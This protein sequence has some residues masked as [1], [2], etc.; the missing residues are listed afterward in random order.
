MPATVTT[1]RSADDGPVFLTDHPIRERFPSFKEYLKIC[2]YSAFAELS[3]G[4]QWAFAK[5][6]LYRVLMTDI[7]ARDHRE[8]EFCLSGTPKMQGKL[9]EYL[10]NIGSP[11]IYMEPLGGSHT[12]H[13]K[14]GDIV[15]CNGDMEYI[16]TEHLFIGFV[17]H[18]ED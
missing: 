1:R 10:V 13:D 6:D 15:P 17:N 14:Y 7:A 9:V 4:N 12:I 18:P 11:P 8:R 16:E 2:P 5:E 3:K